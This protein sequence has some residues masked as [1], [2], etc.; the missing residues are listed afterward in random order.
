MSHLEALRATPILDT[1]SVIGTRGCRITH[2][3][4]VDT[5]SPELNNLCS[6]SCSGQGTCENGQ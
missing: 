5:G 1:Y 4:N 6:R 2:D 3:P